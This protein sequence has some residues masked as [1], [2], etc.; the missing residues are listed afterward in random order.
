MTTVTLGFEDDT[1]VSKSEIA[2]TQLVEAISLFLAGKYL[3]AITL[4]GAAEAVLAGLLA[5]RGNSSVVEE[6]VAAIQRIR[7]YTGLTLI[8]GKTKN[9]AF[10][11]W[12]D[13]RNKLKHHGKN[14]DENLT[15]NLFDEA[16]WM[17]R[18]AAANA[19]KLTLPIVNQGDFENWVIQN[20]NM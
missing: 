15:L 17:I 14:E 10:N 1:N 4:A 19:D 16:Y 20:I 3:C 7:E 6:S 8:G 5:Q 9:E 2:Q 12:N 11:E 18:R 13:A